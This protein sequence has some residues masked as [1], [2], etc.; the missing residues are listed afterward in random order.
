MRRRLCPLSPLLN[1]SCSAHYDIS[2]RMFESFLSADMT[3]SCA[4]W[5][6]EEGG[7]EGDLGLTPRAIPAKAGVDELEVAQM[8]K[9]RTVIERARIGKGDKVLEIGSGWG[10]FAMEVRCYFLPFAAELT[11]FYRRFARRAAPSTLSL[12]PLSKRSSPKL[13]S[14]QQVCRTR[15]RCT[16]D[17]KSV[18]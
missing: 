3:Y 2:N 5:G 15:S 18:V 1:P 10:S 11:R 6:P 7:I 4:I 17:R 16:S 9:I 13:V 12:S 8:R 14:P